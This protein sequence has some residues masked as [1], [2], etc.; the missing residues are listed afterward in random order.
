MKI[1]QAAPTL[2]T[3]TNLPGYSGANNIVMVCTNANDFEYFEIDAS[4][5]PRDAHIGFTTTDS[6]NWWST[7]LRVYL[8]G[9]AGAK[10]VIEYKSE[11]HDSITHSL[12]DWQTMRSQMT[13]RLSDGEIT[14]LRENKK[15]FLS[16]KDLSIKKND[17]RYMVVTGWSSHGTWKINVIRPGR[18]YLTKTSYFIN[19]KLTQLCSI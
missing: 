9:W 18:D 3:P 5:F 13:V 15:S 16:Y 19:S 10:S 17:L 4:E 6:L 7:V 1:N 11:I 8:A 12:S 14:V 2:F